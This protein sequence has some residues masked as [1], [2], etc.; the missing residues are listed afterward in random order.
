MLHVDILLVILCPLVF[1]AGWSARGIRDRSDMPIDRQV[2]E[3]QR[4]DAHMAPLFKAM[5]RAEIAGP[6]VIEGEPAPDYRPP[7]RLPQGACILCDHG[8]PHERHI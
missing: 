3:K 6:L 7:A 4:H 1:W 2:A 5:R 8:I